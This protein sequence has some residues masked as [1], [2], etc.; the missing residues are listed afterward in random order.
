[1]PDMEEPRDTQPQPPGRPARTPKWWPD[2]P[3][4]PPPPNHLIPR[5]SGRPMPHAPTDIVWDDPYWYA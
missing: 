2:Y 3:L 5:E 4:L 1:M